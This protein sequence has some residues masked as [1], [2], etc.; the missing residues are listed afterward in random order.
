M[1]TLLTRRWLVC[2]FLPPRTLQVA[3]MTANES[4]DQTAPEA[5]EGRSLQ[6]VQG[7]YLRCP[8]P[9]YYT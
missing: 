6:E 4:E 8:S 7:H 2:V 5:E 3:M 1:E 9:R